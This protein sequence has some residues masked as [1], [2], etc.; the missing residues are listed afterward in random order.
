MAHVSTGL[1]PI[2]DEMGDALGPSA[3]AR[4]ERVFD[5]DTARML[6]RAMEGNGLALV[7][8]DP[9]PTNVLT[10]L[11][12]GGPRAPLYLI[13]RQ[14]F[15][16]SLRL[17]LGASDL[18]RA[19]V[20]YWP[21]DR[22]RALQNTVLQ[23]Y[24]QALLENGVRSYSLDDLQTD[25]SLCACMAALTAVEWGS[26]QDAL[27]EMKWFW[28]RQLNRALLLLEDCETGFE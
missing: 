12:A 10:P 6:D 27:R 4:L 24:H 20:P 21:E 22:R 13:D 15:T 2:L 3:R 5:D 16:W 1:G 9:N 28:E 8:G 25:W 23:S 11:A 7:H 19:A 14:P 17:W 26:D 18:V